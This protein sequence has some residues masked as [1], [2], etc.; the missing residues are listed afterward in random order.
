[1]SVFERRPALRWAVPAGAAALFVAG[2]ALA[3]LGAV[4]DSG[5]PA[6]TA[7]ELLV[8]LQER[9]PVPVSGT[10]ATRADLGLPDLPMGM[11]PDSGPLALASGERTLRMWTDGP[12]RQRLA[13]I[14]RAAE[15]TVVRN[16]DVAWVWS[17][18]DATATR[19]EL[20]GEGPA[21]GRDAA[22]LPPGVT[23]PSTP[24]EAAEMALA[25]LDPT[26]EVTTSG[27]AAVAG[28]DAYEL[29]LTP[30]D[31]DTLVRVVRVALDAE[32]S[33]PL[34]VQV[35]STEIA[36]PAFEVGF[37]SV[38]FG[39]ADPALFEFTP[40]PGATVEQ[41]D[42][43]TP[44]QGGE[45]TDAQATPG[46]Q[47]TVVGS[48]WSAV[49]VGE[50]PADALADLAESGSRASAEEWGSD[51]PAATALA[52]VEA[53]PSTSGDWGSGRVLAGTLFSAILTDDGR[54][55]VGAVDPEAL[56]AA[57]AGR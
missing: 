24:Q 31:A 14:E 12:T 44:A 40:P 34:R 13:L 21:T 26:T 2:S 11:A 37:T 45:P 56:G 8:A 20:P 23:L 28:R 7:E 3:P 17:S 36:D 16:G 15:T 22:E 19:I 50:L 54:F 18:A 41:R 10:V 30:R 9:T 6:R 47:P 38:D 46:P 29:L 39:T 52:L 5:L 42:V 1:V 55:A 49:L 25:A 48:G 33:T 57:L 35:Y 51:D 4:A 27:L 32:T 43:P 53:L